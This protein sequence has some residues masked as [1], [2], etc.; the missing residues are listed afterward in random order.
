ME[1]L[2]F[3][4]ASMH[5]QRMRDLMEEAKIERFLNEKKNREATHWLQRRLHRQRKFD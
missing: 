2:T 5:K 1:N 4:A 3:T